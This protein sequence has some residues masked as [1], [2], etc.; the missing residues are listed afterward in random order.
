M[1]DK[2]EDGAKAYLLAEIKRHPLSTSFALMLFLG[3]AFALTDYP[4]LKALGGTLIALVA[5]L[6]A[7]AALRWVGEY[8]RV[9]HRIRTASFGELRSLYEFYFTGSRV[10][11]LHVEERD[12]KALSQDRILGMVSKAPTREGFIEVRITEMAFTY[13]RW[14]GKKLFARLPGHNS[15]K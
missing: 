10:L 9:R 2:G 11:S 8:L 6:P 12:A 5:T 4:W 1:A 13:L 15:P 3:G 7:A 14:H